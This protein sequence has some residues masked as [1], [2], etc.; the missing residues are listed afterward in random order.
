MS[1]S[2]KQKQ[3]IKMITQ[4]VQLLLTKQQQNSTRMTRIK[5]IF[6]DFLCI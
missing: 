4:F 1:W 5:Q 3:K 6:A 2:E